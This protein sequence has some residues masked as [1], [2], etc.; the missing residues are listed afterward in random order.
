MKTK[1]NKQEMIVKDMNG[2]LRRIEQPHNF[3]DL[4][5]GF[6][7]ILC[8]VAIATTALSITTASLKESGIFDTHLKSG[9]GRRAREATRV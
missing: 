1:K 8:G 4:I 9:I 2:R 6:V 5:G 3:G 7:S